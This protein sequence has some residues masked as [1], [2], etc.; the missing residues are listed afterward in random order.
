[1]HNNQIQKNNALKEHYEGLCTKQML[2]LIDKKGFYD[3]IP[4][5]L[6]TTATRN[7]IAAGNFVYSN[8]YYFV[9]VS[10]IISKE[11]LLELKENEI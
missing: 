3:D 2:P 11:L 9:K 10:C 5:M 1:V 6:I 4:F 7:G 8:E